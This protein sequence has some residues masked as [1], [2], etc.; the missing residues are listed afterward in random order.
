[1]PASKTIAPQDTRCDSRLMTTALLLL[2]AMAW[3]LSWPPMDLWPM[4]FLWAALLIRAVLGA[5]NRWWMAVTCLVVYSLCWAWLLRWSMEV[6]GPGYPIMALYSAVW[7]VL[8]V[9]IYRR[10]AARGFLAGIPQS[11]AAPVIWLGIEYLRAEIFLGAWP[12]Y[13]AGM[14]LVHWPGVGTDCRSRRG[15][16]GRSAGDDG[17][18][19]VGPVDDA[20]CE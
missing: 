1:M 7:M 15:L 11:V 17:R 12:W 2:S 16:D 8:F 20:S 9:A 18:Y 6:S 14:P 10:L 5:R 4:S 3:L 13:L 19:R